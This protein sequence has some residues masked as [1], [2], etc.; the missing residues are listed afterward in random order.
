MFLGCGGTG[1]AHI[2]SASTERLMFNVGSNQI[3]L[4]TCL[5]LLI[6]SGT[7]LTYFRQQNTLNSLE[8]EIEAKREEQE[9]IQTLQT[10]LTKARARLDTLRQQWRT[11]YKIIP[12]TVSS[13]AAVNYLTELTQTGF[14]TFNVTSGGVEERNGYS[15]RTFSA[16]GEASFKSLYRFVWTVENNRPFYR[17]RDLSLSYLEK[18][19]QDEETS[20]TK[21]DVLVSFQMN[22][23]AVYGA[24]D[25]I[26]QNRPSDEREVEGLPVVQTSTSPPLPSSVLPDPAPERNPFYPLVFEQIPPNEYGRLNVESATLVSI[27]DGRAVFKTGDGFE[28]VAEGDRVYLGR[29]VEVNS[30]K[31]RVVARLN[32]GGVVEKV[33]FT[34]DADSLPQRLRNR[35][36]QN[37]GEQQE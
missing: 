4:V 2:S 25:K 27:I 26:E 1:A 32:K 35:E 24:V 13:P 11:R 3:L 14:E 20:R 33:E 5:V 8:Q 12:E 7:Y 23:Q 22:V 19:T 16:E 36:G 30:T 9:N 15:V 21:M 17:I 37:S 31:G 28:R 18:R 29:I 34:L 10:N 6:A